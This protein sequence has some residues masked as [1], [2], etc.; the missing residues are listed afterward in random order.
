[1]ALLSFERRYRVRGGTL[2]A[3]LATL[4]ALVVAAM[5]TDSAEVMNPLRANLLA[6]CCTALLIGASAD[7]IRGS[8]ARYRQVVGQIPV[9]LYSGRFLRMP[10]PGSPSLN[11][12]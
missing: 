1:M 3:C 11:R 9:V 4:L 5:R 12:T 2:V 8:E 10:A 6:Q 7:W